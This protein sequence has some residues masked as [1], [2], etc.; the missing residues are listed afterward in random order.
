MCRVYV[1]KLCLSSK[2][3]ANVCVQFG[4]ADWP[5]LPGVHA[6]VDVQHPIL[7]LIAP[8]IVDMAA[9]MDGISI[10]IAGAVPWNFSTFEARIIGRIVPNGADVASDLRSQRPPNASHMVVR[11]MVA[12]KE[13]DL[14]ANA[15]DVF[16]RLGSSAFAPAVLPVIH[17]VADMDEQIVRLDPLLDSTD[18]SSIVLLNG[19]EG[20]VCPIDD[21]RRLSALE[22]EV[23]SEKDFHWSWVDCFVYNSIISNRVLIV[24]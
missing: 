8:S 3:L 24:N 1:L 11:V 5:I 21:P 7:D 17:E 14:P 13:D 6:D 4:F 2:H 20:A 16:L 15:L 10:I 9:Q 22:V 19:L 18:Q 12:F 23:A